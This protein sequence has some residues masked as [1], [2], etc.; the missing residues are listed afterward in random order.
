MRV[1]IL[2]Q[3]F[4]PE[5][6]LINDVVDSLRNEGCE[7]SVLT[8]QPNY[9]DGYIFPGYSAWGFGTDQHATGYH[10]H[11]VPI[12]TR[13]KGRWR[14]ALNYA[15]FVFSASLLG[16]FLTRGRQFDIVL[17]YGVSP[18][19]QGLPGIIYRQLKGAALV[20]WV[21]DLWPDA[22]ESTG[23]VTNAGTLGAV[24]HL[25]RFIYHKSD[26]LLAQSRGF[27]DRLRELAGPTHISF[28][29]NPGQD[30][31]MQGNEAILQLGTG[32]NVVFA[33]NLGTA[34]ALETI[35]QAAE[36]IRNADINLVLIGTGSRSKWLQDQISLRNIS[37]VALAGRF[38]REAMPGILAQ[39]SALLVTL[40]RSDSLAL[41]IPSKIP[42]YL[43]AG[44]PIVA[45]LDGEATAII[46]ES[47]AGYAVPAE[48]AVAL[49]QAIEA[50][51]ALTPSERE[52]MG[53][54][55]RR[56]FD[57]HFAPTVLAKTMVEQFRHAMAIRRGGQSN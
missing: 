54:A 37:N 16:P 45:S 32:F 30:A 47:G 21:Q 12:V 17:V 35:L 20:V 18:I 42:S 13:G 34:Q 39:A 3:Y 49:A 14:R 52:A 44:R 46:K 24:R 10:I 33:G 41:T 5:S 51:W 19:L 25:T 36:L 2:S 38:P 23:Y 56:Y 1:L 6:F 8:G 28:H 43:A 50:M 26:L 40:N 22:L 29:P 48:D 27:V 53:H 55:G 4:W 57:T 31:A 11:R 9:P 15:S 7:V